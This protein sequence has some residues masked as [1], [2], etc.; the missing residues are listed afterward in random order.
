M[1]G[2]FLCLSVPAYLTRSDFFILLLSSLLHLHPLFAR[3]LCLQS[4]SCYISN[5]LERLA[6]S[7]NRRYHHSTI[8]TNCCAISAHLPAN[9]S[10]PLTNQQ[11]DRHPPAKQRHLSRGHASQTTLP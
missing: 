5:N 4:I 1:E 8:R 11:A 9:Y 10:R 7:C 2:T 3:R 6:S